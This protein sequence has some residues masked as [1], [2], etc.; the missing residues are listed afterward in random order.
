V[1]GIEDGKLYKALL[2]ARRESRR[3]FYSVKSDVS[4]AI[5]ECGLMYRCLK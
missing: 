2:C 1:S 5:E 3:W 4:A